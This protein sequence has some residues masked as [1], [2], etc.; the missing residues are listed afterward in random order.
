VLRHDHTS[1]AGEVKS[2]CVLEA[3]R[4]LVGHVGDQ[5]A[6]LGRIHILRD[7]M[8][9]VAHP[10]IDFDALADAEFAQMSERGV[11]FVTSGD[12]LT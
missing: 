8:S 3:A 12:P 5:P 11:R 7:C 1:I 6:T 2:H 4:Q 10:T 9:A